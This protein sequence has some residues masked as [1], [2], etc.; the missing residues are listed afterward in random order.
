MSKESGSRSES[1]NG[2]EP[3][4]DIENKTGKETILSSS[5]MKMNWKCLF[6]RL[7]LC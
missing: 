7:E 3:C 5:G 4:S 6:I 1:Y 2:L